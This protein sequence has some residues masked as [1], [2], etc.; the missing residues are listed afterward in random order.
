MI[1]YS[2]APIGWESMTIGFIRY[3]SHE[4]YMKFSPGAK[5]WYKPYRCSS[6]EADEEC[7]GEHQE[8]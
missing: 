7:T 4:R 1:E 6:C 5:K 8:K 2:P 3:V